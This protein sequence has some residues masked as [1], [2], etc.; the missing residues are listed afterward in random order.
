M[1]WN[2]FFDLVRERVSESL[3]PLLAPA[4]ADAQPPAPAN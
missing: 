4:A 2:P 1:S 3:P